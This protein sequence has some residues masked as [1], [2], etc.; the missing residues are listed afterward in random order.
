MALQNCRLSANLDVQWNNEGI[1]KAAHTKLLVYIEW[2]GMLVV[3]T[4]KLIDTKPWL[5]MYLTIKKIFDRR[6]SEIVGHL[7]TKSKYLHRFIWLLIAI[8]TAMLKGVQSATVCDQQATNA[9]VRSRLKENM[10]GETT[11]IVIST[12]R[13]FAVECIHYTHI[14][15]S[16][17]N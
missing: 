8:D 4:Y 5:P 11:V 2:A 17:D 12:L 15:F 10:C 1:K 9:Y 14:Q 7:S 13:T 16:N 3:S 6:F